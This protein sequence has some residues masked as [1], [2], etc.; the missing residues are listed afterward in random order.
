MFIRNVERRGRAIT[1]E[2]DGFDNSSLTHGGERKKER[3]VLMM[4]N[5]DEGLPLILNFFF[6]FEFID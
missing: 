3:L 2:T 4:V 1:S 5:E 6:F